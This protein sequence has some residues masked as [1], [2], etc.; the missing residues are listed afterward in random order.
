MNEKCPFSIRTLIAK[1]SG[2]AADVP[3]PHGRL[4]RAGASRRQLAAISQLTRPIG[5][6]FRAGTSASPK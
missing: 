1:E 4:D 2:K 5:K 3:I 6:A